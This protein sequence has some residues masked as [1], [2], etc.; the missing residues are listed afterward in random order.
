MY[1]QLTH[2]GRDEIDA[3]LQTTFSNTFSWMKMYEFRLR[4]HWRLFLKVQLTIFQHW[5]RKWL[6]ADQAT[7]HYLNQWWLDHWCIYASLGLNELKHW[8]S[9]PGLWVTKKKQNMPNSKPANKD[10]QTWHPTGLRLSHYPIRSHVRKFLS[11]NMDSTTNFTQALE[12]AYLF[13]HSWFIIKMIGYQMKTKPL[14][15]N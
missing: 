14:M 8:I 9:H 4:F 13:G 5:F 2:W 10:P 7:S 3:I 11:T 12:Y 1:Q 6:G 15:I